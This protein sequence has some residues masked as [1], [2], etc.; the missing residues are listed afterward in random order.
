[1]GLG[2]PLKSWAGG[3]AVATR[4]PAVKGEKD[5]SRAERILLPTSYIRLASST[6]TSFRY[7]WM[8]LDCSTTLTLSLPRGPSLRLAEAT[9]GKGG[10]LA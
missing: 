8:S 5:P 2:I 4:P 10:P 1:V 9:E 6:S 7:V 3:R